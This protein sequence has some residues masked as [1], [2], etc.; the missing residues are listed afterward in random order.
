MVRLKTANVILQ[1]VRS[2]VGLNPRHNKDEIGIGDF[3]Q[4][5]NLMI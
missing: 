2:G 4:S 3:N 1:A 5:P